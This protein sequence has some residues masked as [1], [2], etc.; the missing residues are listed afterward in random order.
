[1][2]HV[3]HNIDIKNNVWYFL[4]AMNEGKK[5]HQSMAAGF[6]TATDFVSATLEQMLI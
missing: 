5:I 4:L 3:L 2:S 6:T 1:V